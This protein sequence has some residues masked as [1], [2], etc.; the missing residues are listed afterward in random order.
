[1]VKRNE[2]NQKSASIYCRAT[3]SKVQYNKLQE[4]TQTKKIKN[5]YS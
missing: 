2:N 1:M 3:I 5:D 4:V